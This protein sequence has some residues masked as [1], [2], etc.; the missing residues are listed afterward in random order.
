MT[1][2][3]MFRG[4]YRWLSNFWPAVVEYEGQLYPTVENAYQAAKTSDLGIRR[5][6]Q[7][8]SPGEA[9]RMGGQ[10]VRLRDDWERVKDGI[11]LDL[12]KQKFSHGE[13]RD[14]LLDTG[15]YQIIEGNTWGD[16][17]WGVDA[18]TGVG[19][20]VL[21]NIIMLVRSELRLE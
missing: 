5:I 19:R 10:V 18:A 11:M 13:L 16:T 4:D 15:E 1:D 21:G 12:V 9:K 8:V 2:I 17:Y 14:K 6:M 20:N 3:L 7:R